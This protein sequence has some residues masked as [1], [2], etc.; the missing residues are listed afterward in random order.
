MVWFGD[1][2]Q[3]AVVPLGRIVETKSIK[4]G[5]TVKVIWNNKKQYTATFILSGMNL[6]LM[7]G[8]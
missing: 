2:A 7:V 8:I 6:K 1:E 5:D 3:Y 4:D